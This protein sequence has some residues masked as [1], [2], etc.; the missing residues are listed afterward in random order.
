M[1]AANDGVSASNCASAANGTPAA[2]AAKTATATA[3]K[4]KASAK[5]A[6]TNAS[7]ASA[8]QTSSGIFSNIGL[9]YLGI[10][11]GPSLAK[12]LAGSGHDFVLHVPRAGRTTTES[13]DQS[14][15][16]L[17]DQLRSLGSAVHVVNDAD[18]AKRASRL[19]LLARVRDAVHNVADFSKIAG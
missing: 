13:P 9:S 10:F 11:S 14:V 15:E 1:A 17:V 7:V 5:S 6:S 16:V 8:S 3:T 2:Q 12:V 19:A 4:A 18:P